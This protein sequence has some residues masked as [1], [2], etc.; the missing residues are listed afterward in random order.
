MD[1]VTVKKIAEALKAAV[2]AEQ[3][4]YHFYMMAARSTEDEQGSAVFEELANEELDHVRYLTSQY[5][6]LMSD[7]VFDPKANLGRRTDLSGDSPI[8]SDKLKARAGQAHFEMSALSI[9]MNLELNAVKFYQGQADVSDDAEVK[10]FFQELADWESGHYEA[11]SRQSE[12]LKEDYW[13]DN[14]F[15]PY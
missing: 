11:L 3:N 2:E 8:F 4:G 10:A 6:S 12:L 5:R 9:G 7:G 15:A 13:S 1:A 14:G